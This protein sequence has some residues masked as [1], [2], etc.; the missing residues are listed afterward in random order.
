MSNALSQKISY[1]LK[2][3]NLS[4][5]EF[6]KTAGLSKSSVSNIIHGRSK[7]P[8]IDLIHTIAKNLGC[9]IEYLIEPYTQEKETFPSETNYRLAADA[10]N[11]LAEHLITQGMNVSTIDF[12]KSAQ[13]IYQF[14]KDSGQAYID[15]RFIKWCIK[16]FSSR[17]EKLET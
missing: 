10:A 17:E 16:K 3:K 5:N 6:E 1:L 4:I 11:R 8:S 14:T 12:Y 15:E 2:Q 13:E 7:S 9:T